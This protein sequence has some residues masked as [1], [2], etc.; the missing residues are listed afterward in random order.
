MSA[1]I[2]I[3]ESAAMQHTLRNVFRAMAIVSL[4]VEVY[5][6]ARWVGSYWS[7]KYPGEIVAQG[8]YAGTPIDVLYGPYWCPATILLPLPVLWI[9]LET[10][11][12]R[13]ERRA[14]RGQ[15]WNCGYDLCGSAKPKC[16][17]CGRFVGEQ[18]RRVT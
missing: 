7:G 13:Y 18:G 17:E 12:W 1:N 11:S 9:W 10:H 16:P 3:R 15:C 8:T 6:V 4:I 14:M 2:S 5:L